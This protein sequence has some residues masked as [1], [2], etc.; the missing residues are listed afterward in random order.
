MSRTT[1]GRTMQPMSTMPALR[2]LGPERGLHFVE[3]PVP[4]PA[5]DEV[6]VEVEAASVCGTDL[7]I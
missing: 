7:H 6:L 1:A 5:A 4:V 2:K 3:L